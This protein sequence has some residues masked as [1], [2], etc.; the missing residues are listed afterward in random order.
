M[1]TAI[2]Q[3]SHKVIKMDC[4]HFNRL[5]TL[6]K[7]KEVSEEHYKW[8]WEN[9]ER[10]DATIELISDLNLKSYSIAEIGPG[11]LGLAAL[12]NFPDVKLEAYDCVEWFKPVYDQFDISWNDL[13]LNNNID[14]PEEK[15]DIILLC[16]VI[17]HLAHW[18]IEIFKNLTKGLK[19]GGLLLVTTQNLHR[20]S[21]RLRMILGKKMFADFIPESLV[22]GHL[23]E[24]MPEE[25]TLLME[26][27]G[28][29][30][31]Q[32]KFACFPDLV[33][34]ST[35]QKGYSIL[36][37]VSPRLSNHFFCWGYKP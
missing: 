15:Y 23:R 1:E 4:M 33:S 37:R 26:H 27:A 11:G 18:P 20:L 25:M 3:R 22:M 17:E 21:N 19:S 5:E 16:E 24:Y 29:T 8:V 31:I 32:T 30:D 10:I 14:F 34:S 7:T 28:F 9:S 36:C 35:I 2:N 13:D 12:Q 6:L